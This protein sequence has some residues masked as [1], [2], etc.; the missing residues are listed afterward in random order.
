MAGEWGVDREMS[1]CQDGSP[2][3][4][5]TTAALVTFAQLWPEQVVEPVQN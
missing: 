3:D 5:T 2:S 4:V 1:G